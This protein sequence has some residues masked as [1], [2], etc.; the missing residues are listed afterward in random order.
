MV[1]VFVLAG[2]TD[3]NIDAPLDCEATDFDLARARLGPLGRIQVETSTAGVRL[4]ASQDKRRIWSTQVR[5]RDCTLL[6]EIAEIGV[7]RAL[8]RPSTSGAVGDV[9]S[10]ADGSTSAEIGP[11]WSLE[12]GAGALL[13]L[14][15]LRVGGIADLFLRRGQ[16]GARMELGAVA[17]TRGDVRNGADVIGRLEWFSV[18]GLVGP[19]A[20]PS[21]PWLPENLQPCVGIAGG[22]EWVRASVFGERL[23]RTEDGGEVLERVDGTLRV[24]WAPET[25][26]LET[27]IRGTWRPNRPTFSLEGA[28]VDTGLAFWSASI[29]IRGWLKIF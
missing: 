21:P 4:T 23:F 12:A 2:Q 16:L 19:E 28:E 24:G 22:V 3:E 29:G 5:S 25:G 13:E 17:P 1:L 14:D 6:G 8:R 10:L 9:P 18:H 11:R 26:G 7:E 15:E 27:W 20:C